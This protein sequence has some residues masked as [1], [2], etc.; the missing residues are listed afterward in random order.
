[1]SAYTVRLHMRRTEKRRRRHS[2][3][4]VALVVGAAILAVLLGG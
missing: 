3:I 2:F 1:M 4:R